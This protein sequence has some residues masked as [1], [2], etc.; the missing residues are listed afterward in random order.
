MKTLKFASELVPL[1]ESGEKT[2][3][4]RM[5]DD[6]DLQVGD[7]LNVFNKETG[8][9]FGV[10]TLIAVAVKKISE[11]TEDDWEGHERF[12]SDAE[13]YETYRGYYGD[14]VGP[15]TE[16]KTISFTFKPKLYK[17][18]VVVDE[19]DNIIGAEYI[20]VAIEKGLIRRAARTYVF[21]DS[22]LLLVQQRSKT[23]L[24]PLM[25]DQSA[26]GHVD[27]GE[28]YEEAAKRELYE[29]LGLEGHPLKE[30]V[31]SFWDRDFY[32][33]IYK[34]TV[35]DNTPINFDPEEIATVFWWTPTQVD[36]EMSKNPNQFT[37]A[38][39]AVWSEL[40]DKIIA[41]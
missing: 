25:F 18:C 7:E 38:F 17:K 22:G 10:I 28:T 36:A 37:P 40:K 1:V 11:L 29:E 23:V 14:S 3:T 5:F 13:M 24:K 41:L 12:D 34:I 9:Q 21:N 30:V 26:A 8:Y 16:V 32:N 31:V 39:L 15:E 27:E 33:A 35:P 20:A 6:K 4:F 2:S 19:D